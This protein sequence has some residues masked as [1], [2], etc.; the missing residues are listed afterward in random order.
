MLH[1]V[2]CV[3]GSPL[4]TLSETRTNAEPKLAQKSHLVGHA[5]AMHSPVL[6]ELFKPLELIDAGP[7]DVVPLVV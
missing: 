3:L 1:S 7:C 6:R 2:S 4:A 5:F